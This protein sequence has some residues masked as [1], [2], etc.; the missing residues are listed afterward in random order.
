M[1][2][3]KFLLE[4]A[5]HLSPAER[6]RETS[7]VGGYRPLRKRTSPLQNGEAND[8]PGGVA[9]VVEEHLHRQRFGKRGPFLGVL[10]VARGDGDDGRQD[11]LLRA[12]ASDDEQRR[13]S[14]GNRHQ[15]ARTGTQFH[16]LPLTRSSVL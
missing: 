6:R 4:E 14:Q 9:V 10:A 3:L 7:A 12:L 15:P 13:R 8:E 16:D 1:R 5:M 2:P 11:G